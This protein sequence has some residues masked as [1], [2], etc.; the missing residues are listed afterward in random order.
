MTRCLSLA[1]LALVLL[2]L[3]VVPARG[4]DRPPAPPDAYSRTLPLRECIGLALTNNPDLAVEKFNPDIRDA[5]I[6]SLYGQFDLT[7]FIN[8]T[9]EKASK[10]SGTG[11]EGLVSG[12]IGSTGPTPSSNI[13]HSAGLRK[14]WDLGTVTELTATW[15][16]SKTASLFSAAGPVYDWKTEFT[17]TQPLLRGFGWTYNNSRIFEGEINKL[18]AEYKYAEVVLNVVQN[19]EN[20]YWDLVSADRELDTRQKTFDLSAKLLQTARDK[21][22]AGG[23]PIA[24]VQAEADLASQRDLLLRAE[25]AVP[26]A[27]EALKKQLFPLGDPDYYRLD[28]HAADETPPAF[29][30]P[31]VADLVSHVTDRRPEWK[32][33]RKDIVNK[34]FELI[35][36][37]N[38]ALPK[39][40]FK[41]TYARESNDKDADRAI[42]DSIIENF[43]DY[44]VGFEFEY[45]LGNRD[46]RGKI[47]KAQLEL[48]QSR[49]KLHAVERTIGYEV[50]QAYREAKNALERVD[51]AHKAVDLQGKKLKA[52]SEKYNLGL[53]T[54][55]FVL[56][57]ER[58]LA[59]ARLAEVKTLVDYNKAW[60]K[61]RR[62]LGSAL[63]TY[64]IL[65]PR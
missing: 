39:L 25:V 27:R 43:W 19:V 20:A 64:D 65:P 61:L 37:E 40:N 15:N 60:V 17:L 29:D 5:E 55:Q 31:K 28:V 58:D 54:I 1:A 51:A 49:V 62:A 32:Q 45:P 23:D 36:A 14:T 6:L 41:Y 38:E 48:Q 10:D 16:R 56:Q 11:L 4:D 44:S 8:T 21:A 18:I 13:T 35:R 50:V 52:E 57:Y 26:I 22:A 2:A 3:L 24:V 30:L 46:A 34:V 42:E 9:T 53:A 59:D 63:D 7:A 12:L 47:R 33:A